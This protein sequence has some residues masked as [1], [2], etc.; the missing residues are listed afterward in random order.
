M[1]KLRLKNG[2]IVTP[3]G[4]VKADLGI[5]D[6]KISL[7]TAGLDFDKVIDIEGKYVL[8]GFVDIHFHGYNG[9]DFS[10]GQYDN[11]SRKF[12]ADNE[13]FEAGFDMLSETMAGFGTTGFY[14][15]TVAAG[16][17]VLNK[18]CRALGRYLEKHKAGFGKAKIFGA[19]LEGSFYNKDMAGA[20]NTDFTFDFTKEAFDSID[21]GGVIKLANVVPEMDEQSITLTKYLTDKGIIVGAGH[22]NASCKQFEKAMQ[23]GLK[24]SIHFV[25][26]PTGGSFKPFDNGGTIEAVLK[27]DEVY[28]E[29]ILDGCHINPAYVRDII[30]RKGI[31]KIVGITDCGFMAGANIKKAY[32][33]AKVTKVSEDGR[34][35]SVVGKKNVLAGSN[36]TMNRGFENLLNWL[37]CDMDGIWN[38]KH[39]AMSLEQGLTATTKMCSTNACKLT[40]LDEKGLGSIAQ[41]NVA[42]IC[43]VDIVRQN[44]GYSLNIE[45]TI[46]D[47]KI[48]YQK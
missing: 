8:P 9:F 28:A 30:N 33:G 17:K 48:V 16:P 11:D 21:D 13:I 6:G 35:I 3:G 31:D 42:D 18:C 15:A 14:L 4:V 26:G 39:K 20:L 41:G 47:G 43:L 5:I 46:V 23:V 1:P 32:N 7:E 29:L 25:N 40:A 44:D 37:C 45:K 10:L 34:Y 36:L 24:Y 2:N 27:N 22:T 19:M 12:T 38:A